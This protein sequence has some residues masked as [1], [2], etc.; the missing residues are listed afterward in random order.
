MV[1]PS[2]AFKNNAPISA[3]ATTMRRI[4]DNESSAPLCYCSPS[5]GFKLMKKGPPA[6]LRVSGSF[7]YPASEW[8]LRIT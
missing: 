5:F 2:F 3:L 8:M 4:V 7:K 6:L 1:T